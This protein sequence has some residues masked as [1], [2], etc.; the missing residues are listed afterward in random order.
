MTPELVAVV[1]A[2]REQHLLP[3]ADPGALTSKL[4]TAERQVIALLASGRAP[5]Q[6][7]H[8]LHV[9]LSTVRSHIA[10]A[11]RKTGACTLEQLVAT[12]ADAQV[13]RR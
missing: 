2:G 8:E 12:C 6:A 10:A 11:K 9:E 13:T 3:R 1:A 7:A 4:T 5:K